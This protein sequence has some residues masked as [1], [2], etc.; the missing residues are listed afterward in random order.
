MASNRPHTLFDEHRY[1]L[2][3]RRDQ[4]NIVAKPVLLELLDALGAEKYEA[5]VADTLTDA[6]TPQEIR[7]KAQTALVDLE[8]RDYQQT[9]NDTRT[10]A[11][12]G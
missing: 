1:M 8:Q 3:A 10:W 5:W 2:E 7:A 12:G 9:V 6:D 11:R 4:F